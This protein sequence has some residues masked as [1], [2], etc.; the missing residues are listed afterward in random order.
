MEV[1]K[2]IEAV[3]QHEKE[4]QAFFFWRYPFDKR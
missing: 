3:G 2:G 1:N 4:L